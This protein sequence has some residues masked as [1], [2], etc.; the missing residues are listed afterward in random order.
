[1]S[2]NFEKTDT[3]LIWG[4]GGIGG[5]FGASF[6]HAGYKVLFVD[7]NKEHVDAINKNGISLEGPVKALHAR[8][9][10]CL[11]EEVQ[12]VHK[13]A[14]LGVKAHQTEAA[15]RQMLPHLDEE[16]VIVSIQ[17]GLNEHSITAIA[18]T[19]RT[20][21]CFVNLGGEY[22]APGRINYGLRGAVV[23]GELYG[24]ISPRAHFVHALL[25]EFDDEAL[26]TENIWG[27][28]WGKMVYGT[29][30]YATALSGAP[31]WENFAHEKYQEVFIALGREIAAIAK[32]GGITL[33]AFDGFEPSAFAP[34][35]TYEAA[36]ANLRQLME[37]N[38]KNPERRSGIWRDL[39]VYKRPTEID[40]Q[41]LPMLDLAFMY[42]V[43]AP[44]TDELT[45]LIHECEEGL[46][47]SWDNLELL[48]KAAQ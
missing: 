1:M 24:N 8:A 23:C 39:V 43:S 34:E 29:M 15:V 36:C 41:L 28:L 30:L 32:A 3:I 31:I 16:G 26:L 44:L 7:I 18:G 9:E 20:M 2:W 45:C 5:A 48:F 12:G 22:I 27:Y 11:P 19:E 17:N 47:L 21:G 40:G 42:G 35:A 38:K 13:L 46:P 10:A 4:A 6:A 33:E 14:F 37:Y 25:Q